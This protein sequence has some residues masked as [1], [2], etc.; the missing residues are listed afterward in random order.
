MAAVDLDAFDM[1]GPAA[2]AA[3]LLSFIPPLPCF[4]LSK[5]L[6]SPRELVLEVSAN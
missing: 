5:A 3:L 4:F 6:S 1:A 2:D